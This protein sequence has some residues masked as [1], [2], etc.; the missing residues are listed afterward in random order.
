MRRH[1]SHIGTL[2]Y[3]YLTDKSPN[4]KTGGEIKWNFTK[5]L[6]DK[7]GNVINRFESPV[8]PEAAELIKAV[9][10]ALAQ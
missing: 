8:T 4:P 10:A 6:V 2:K 3:Q 9:E 1:P 5:F 7:N